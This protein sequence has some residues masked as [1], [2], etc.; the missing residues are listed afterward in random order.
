[1]RPS[2]ALSPLVLLLRTQKHVG[3]LTSWG[4]FVAARSGGSHLIPQWQASSRNVF[5]LNPLSDREQEVLRR[6][7]QGERATRRS[8]AHLGISE[9]TIKNHINHIMS[10]LH[11]SDRTQAVTIAVQRGSWI[12]VRER[13]PGGRRR[14]NRG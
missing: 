11:A 13:Q 10:K 6:V 8:L 12:W 14:G 4:Q 9:S 7:A 5:S 2:I 3:H 1:M